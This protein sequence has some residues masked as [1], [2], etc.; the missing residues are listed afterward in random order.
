MSGSRP[1]VGIRISA[2][3]AD[4]ARR[5]LE[6]VGS[7]GDAA[8]R[9]VGTASAAA[10][11]EMQRLSVAS[12]VANRTFTSMGGSL[13]RVGATF[14][15]VSGVA[16]GL[17]AGFVALGAAAAVS[18]TAIAQ[19]GDAATATL[20]RLT[21][22]TGG[23]GQAQ[24]VYQR[25]FELSQQTGVAVAESAGSFQRFS[26]AAKEIGGT[27]DQVLKLV[28]GIQKAGIV[29]GA[30][31]QE[32]G[33]AVQQLGQ[34][35]ASGTLQGDELRSLLENMPQLA[36]ALAREMGVGVGQLRQMGS[37]GKLTA[38]VVFPALLRA[39]EKIGDEFDKMPVT[40]SRAKDILIAATQDFGERLDRITGLSQTFAR[41]MQQGASALRAAGTAI[42][43]NEREAADSAVAA[44]LRRQQQVAAQVAAERAAS[45]YGDVPAGLAE[46]SRIADEELREALARQNA[47]RRDDRELQR[48]EAEA[49]AQQAREAART[50]AT[51]GLRA[52]ASDLDAKVKAREKYA[53]R[54]RK[55]DEMEA[56]GGTLPSGVTFASLRLAAEKELADALEKTAGAHARVAK[57]AA[58]ADSHVKAYLKEQEKA[59]EAVAKAQEK[60]AR[61]IERFHQ[62]SF[63]AVA[64]IGERAFD[65]V[66]D[67]LVQAFVSGEGAAVNFG[68]VLRGVIASAV[69]DIAK[70]AVVNPILN[71]VFTSSTGARPTLA[72]A[73]GGSA[74][75]FGGFGGLGSI[76]SSG[77]D[78]LSG[79]GYLAGGGGLSGALFGTPGSLTAG[80]GA[81]GEAIPATAGMFG[82][83]G[84]FSFGSL[85]STLGGIG[86]GFGLGST[87]GGF[88]ANSRAQQQNAQIGAALGSL[89]G[90]FGGPLGSLIGGTL[91]GGLG[92]LIGPGESVNAWGYAL[93]SNGPGDG[94]GAGTGLQPI[95]RRY[96][97]EAG[98][99]QFAQ[100]DAA[101]AA[102][103]AFLAQN[104]LLVGGAIG[105]GGN[106]NGPEYGTNMVG[107][108]NEAFSKLWFT[109]Q[110]NAGLGS[111]ISGRSFED[112]GKLQEFVQGFLAIEATIQALTAETVPAFTA[113]LK[114]V[115]DNFDAVSKQAKE[116]G[117][118]EAGLAEARAKA[119]DELQAQ[120]VEVLRQSDVSLYV[121][122]LAAAGNT[123]QAELARQAEAARLE[124]E[125]LGR[126]LDA[127]ALPAEQRAARLLALEET[128]AAERLAIIQRYGEQAAAALRQAGGSIR[129]YLDNLASG[130]AAG[131]SPTD[132]LAAAQVAFERD[133]TLSMGGDRDA[134]GRIT[135]SADALLAAGRDM[136][137]SGPGFQALLESVKGGLGSLPVVQSYDAMQAASL[138]AIQQAIESGT[139][140][141]ATTILPSGNIVQIAGGFSV[142]GVEIGLAAVNT[143]LGAMHVSQYAIGEATN[144]VL[145]VLGE[146]TASAATGTVVGLAAL[147]TSLHTINVSLADLN[148][149]LHT[150]NVSTVTGLGGVADHVAAVNASAVAGLGSVGSHINAL[151]VSTVS[152]LSGL[153][154]HVN[155]GTAATVVGLG[156]LAG[157]INGLNAATVVGLAALNTSLQTI[158]A[159]LADLNTSLHTINVSTVT[160]L[161]AVANHVAAV[162]AST[163]AG[164]SSVAQHVAAGSAATTAA[165][166]A[167]HAKLGSPAA[168]DNALLGPTLNLVQL[169]QAINGNV[170]PLAGLAAIGNNALLTV[171]NHAAAGAAGLANVN[172][173]LGAVDKSVRDVNTSLA[174][175]HGAIA[176]G[177]GAVAG[178]VAALNVSTVA[179]LNGVAA[180]VD[181][182]TA[183][184][185][186][187]LASIAGHINALNNTTVAGL[188]GV[189][190]STVAGDAALNVSLATIN[191]ST[192]TG[193]ASV[194][195]S[196]AAVNTMALS[197]GQATHS[198][199]TAIYSAL[200][201]EMQSMRAE[202]MQLRA[203][204]QQGATVT[205]NETRQAGLRVEGAVLEVKS[206]I[207][208]AA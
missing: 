186:V 170:A 1:S 139:L 71:S 35:L 120:R 200:I 147:N 206:A 3:G 80:M 14:S 78:F 7:A 168:N 160:G 162:N 184:A 22:A 118:S 65:R 60:A 103:N 89:L 81:F 115:N 156:S 169:G 149:S 131:A 62:R 28:A 26:V 158:N 5:D 207:R 127:M 181:A 180:Q 148:T 152:G 176:N 20:A 45:A 43:P 36:Q 70:L 130:T 56:R 134:L 187:G 41:F 143:T 173:S 38:D 199:L 194:N 42:A 23:L 190:V 192:V 197:V 174:T 116:L 75:S 102:I 46:A 48:A 52:L 128:Q 64:N 172:A 69:A 59:A 145:A 122:N 77:W 55:L 58:D 92:G 21:S 182:G 175:V 9:R 183:A 49:A 119:L 124:I 163:V 195:T 66:G 10:T 101:V 12:D 138:A 105:V 193:L 93:R 150:I 104:N 196:L 137:A 177:L 107:S 79:G 67:A 39:T 76:V 84:S 164:L 157:H 32:T 29:A 74:T 151:N 83:G 51:I 13:G 6:A 153:A 31:A 16:A 87:L 112:P 100:A 108:F 73:F 201:F 106:K 129:Q 166:S 90:S 34:A 27:N 15:G 159:S 94:A 63:D 188:S 133:R 97:N 24:A 204:V 167:I 155:A 178:H 110:D 8:M 98:A 30:S 18:A 82:A 114:A 61:E 33:A 72:G 135:G 154:E 4:K 37:E 126:A 53:E 117:V 2:E 121:R 86:G 40:M 85:G 202:L 141:T 88:I 50:T 113:S 109:S 140:N 161:A 54:I 132:R 99:Q 142:A 144:A 91:G 205:A 19:A 25:L 198:G 136:Y 189:N 47:I 185:V 44:A 57:E 125:A 171:A 111:A 123:Q 179:G 165:L 96:Y 11:P 191:A 208:D 17:T 203:T 95:D 68:G 146:I